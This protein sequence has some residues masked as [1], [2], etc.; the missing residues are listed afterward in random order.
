[1]HV[2]CV[3][4]DHDDTLIP[5]FPVRAR[6]LEQAVRTVLGRQI[7]GRAYLRTHLGETIERSAERLAG[8]DGALAG[9][10]VRAYRDVYYAMDGATPF[11]GIAR[12]LA[13]LREA[14]LRVGVVTSKVR[15][16]AERELRRYGLDALVECVVGAEDVTEHKPAAEP[17]LRALAALGVEPGAALMVGDSAVDLLAARAAGTRSGAALWGAVDAGALLALEPTYRF[18]AAADILST[19]SSQRP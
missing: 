13:G 4:F 14:G 6:A 17:L 10:V 3:L 18:P 2:R 7:D 9:A 8:G 1:M 16:G 5:T 15:W 19:L 12:T 11:P